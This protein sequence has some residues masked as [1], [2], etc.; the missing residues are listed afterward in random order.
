MPREPDPADEA[1]GAGEPF[2]DGTY[3]L[4]RFAPGLPGEP[5][6]AAT[7]DW[8]R[9]VGAGFYDKARDDAYLDAVAAM[10]AADERE[11]TGVY[12]RGPVPPGTLGEHIPVA[13]FATLRKTLNAG[14]GRLVP[15]HLITAVTV[16]TSHRRRGLLRRLMSADLARAKAG[17]VPIAALTASEG[18]IYRRFGFGVATSERSV[19]VDTTRRFALSAAPEGRVEAADPA[20]LLDLGPRIFARV[21][22]LTPGSIDRHDWYRLA[23]AG[24]FSHDGGPDTAIRAA[25]HLRADGQ[26]DGYVAYSF[27]GWDAKPYTVEVKDLVAATHAAYLGLWEFLGSLDLVERVVWREAPADDPLVWALEDPRCVGAKAAQDMLWLRILDVEA[28]LSA[29][30]YDADGGLVLTVTDPLSLASG[31]YRLTV[32][33]GAARVERL[34]PGDAAGA[35]ARLDV[36]DLSSVY[37]GGVSPVTLAAAGRFT[38]LR[39]GAALEAMRLFAVERPAHCLTHF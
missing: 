22:R 2:D 27:R 1:R 12:A 29:R 16:R 37:C 14:F 20:V 39:P 35:D 25:L 26:A 3:V 13:T 21:H 15:A 36:A 7:R 33:D 28:A 4:R 24:R 38:E 17:G 9:A 6:H 11:L 18:S 19:T 10:Y 8:L 32:D 34:A 5:G 30:A 31:T 23:A